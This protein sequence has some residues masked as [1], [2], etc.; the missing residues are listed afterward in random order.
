MIDL[1]K[2]FQAGRAD[3]VFPPLAI[4]KS[5]QAKLHTTVRETTQKTLVE[6]VKQG[7]VDYLASSLAN[8]QGLFHASALY[9]SLVHD[10]GNTAQGLD[11]LHGAMISAG[12]SLCAMLDESTAADIR[13]RANMPVLVGGKPAEHILRPH[14]LVAED[15][16]DQFAPIVAWPVLKDGSLFELD[17]YRILSVV[18][19]H[20]PA[21]V[22]ALRVFINAHRATHGVI[23]FIEDLSLIPDKL[24]FDR[25]CVPLPMGL[26]TMLVCMPEALIQQTVGTDPDHWLVNHKRLDGLDAAIHA[27]RA[28]FA[29]GRLRRAILNLLNGRNVDA[30]HPNGVNA[31][32]LS[33]EA[34]VEAL[35][36][37][38]SGSVTGALVRLSNPS[39]GPDLYGLLPDSEGPAQATEMARAAHG[40][41]LAVTLLVVHHGDWITLAP[42][43]LAVPMVGE[44]PLPPLT[45]GQ[46]LQAEDLEIAI[47]DAALTDWPVA[48]FIGGAA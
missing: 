36:E 15:H 10:T 33:Y 42:V 37:S 47:A 8:D 11:E 30:R 16:H 46:A 19:P 34:E 25:P 48:D 3:P 23:I 27:R 21:D 43:R 1:S 18:C 32:Y 40:N 7:N 45:Q 20:D 35:A 9:M 31:R 5:T 24:V 17:D 26:M 41:R 13:S 39:V 28:A 6:C 14:D 22:D 44:I 38:C 4:N 29:Q 12:V 2:M